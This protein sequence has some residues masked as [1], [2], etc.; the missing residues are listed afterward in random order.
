MPFINTGGGNDSGVTQVNGK[1]GVVFLNHRDVQ[2]IKNIGESV[3]GIEIGSMSNRPNS[4]E[5]NT[6]YISND[7][8]P[9]TIYRYDGVKGEW[10][11]ITAESTD[12]LPEG[13]SNK[14]FTN[15]RAIE[16]LQNEISLVGKTG[17]YNDL[18]NKPD[19]S[20]LEEVLAFADFEGFPVTGEKQKIYIA[21]DTGF[22]YRWTGSTYVKMTSGTALWGNIAG[23]IS[24]Q[25]DLNQALDGKSDVDHTHNLT[26]IEGTEDITANTEARHTHD[27]KNT[28]NDLSESPSGN[29]T[30]KGIEITSG[31]G[32]VWGSFVE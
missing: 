30:Y 9:N 27:N 15:A 28:L 22:I 32:S 3:A 20:V 12:D 5:N 24:D 19:L 13:Q 8:I 6:I 25:Q 23:N 29:L 2:A 1:K 18:T 31:E 7:S 4:A 16:A 14:Y 10:K 11:N 17:D 26:E 21:E